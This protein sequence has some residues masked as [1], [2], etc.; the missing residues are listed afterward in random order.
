MDASDDK[1]MLEE[2][3]M[4]GLSFEAHTNGRTDTAR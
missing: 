2:E 3:Q 4:D 1:W